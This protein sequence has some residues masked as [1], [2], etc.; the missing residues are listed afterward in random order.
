MS[1]ERD[2][3]EDIKHRPEV[4]AALNEYAKEIKAWG[5]TNNTPVRIMAAEDA[6][7]AAIIAAEP[8]KESDVI[9]RLDVIGALISN[10]GGNASG[11]R[12]LLET[13]LKHG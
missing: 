10:L 4:I 9:I 6:L 3:I 11:Y 12:N 1:I 5:M 8:P 7:I 13:K 2:V